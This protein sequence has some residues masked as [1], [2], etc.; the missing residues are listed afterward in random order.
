MFRL[1]AADVISFAFV[2]FNLL[3]LVSYL[4]AVA[5]ADHGAHAISLTCWT[6]WIGANATT[7]YSWVRLDDAALASVSAFNILSAAC[8]FCIADYK[9]IIF[10]KSRIGRLSAAI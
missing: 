4:V 6:V 1:D 9:R 8:V 7:L 5:H 2:L 3:R 10:T